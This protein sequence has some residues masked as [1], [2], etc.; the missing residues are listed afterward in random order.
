MTLAKTGLHVA[1][2]EGGRGFNSNSFEYHYS[3]STYKSF[4]NFRNFTLESFRHFASFRLHF[5]ERIRRAGTDSRRWVFLEG[6]DDIGKWSGGGG[7][8][9][10]G[11][12]IVKRGVL[13]LT[14]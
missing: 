3:D 4:H 10:E 2:L 14:C 12:Y 11:I 9:F 1:C 6:G 7:G 8:F 13:I 5:H